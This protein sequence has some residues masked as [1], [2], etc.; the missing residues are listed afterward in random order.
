MARLRAPVKGVKAVSWANE[1]GQPLGAPVENWRPAG[2][3]DGRELHGHF[4]TLERLSVER[5]GRDLYTANSADKDG[6]MWTYLPFGP[7]A[8]YPDYEA[9]LGPAS[10]SRDP[11]FY[12]IC[13]P[14]G[15]GA[16]R[17][18]GLCAYLRIAPEAGSIEVGALVFSPLLQRTTAAT[19]AMVLMMAHAFALGYRRYEWK[20]DALN[21]AS[22]QAALRLGFRYEG[23]F[24]QATVVKGRNRDTAWYAVTDQEWPRLKDAYGAWLDPSNFEGD[25]GQRQRLSDRTAR[26]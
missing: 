21:A 3:P 11:Y 1:W 24:V 6:R 18:V 7:F 23:T 12:A 25:G 14:S 13:I 22:R 17:A 9:W 26:A 8:D 16:Y 20:C 5:H 10:T 2:R 15:S 19:E 4:C